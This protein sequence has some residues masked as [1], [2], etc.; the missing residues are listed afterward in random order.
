MR[1]NKAKQKAI[2]YY[3]KKA[4]EYGLCVALSYVET[5]LDL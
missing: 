4:I 3:L 5:K 2:E 1:G